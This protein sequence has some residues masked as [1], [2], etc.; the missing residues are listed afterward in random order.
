MEEFDILYMMKTPFYMG[1]TKQV[2]VEADQIDISDED[3]SNMT[4]KNLLLVRALTVFHDLEGL[5]DL[6]TKLKEG[7]SEV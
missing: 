3:D 4:K 7:S 5:R 2:P 6:V 1:N